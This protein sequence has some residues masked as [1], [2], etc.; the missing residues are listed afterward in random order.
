[1]IDMARPIISFKFEYFKIMGIQKEANL[2]HVFQVHYDK[3]DKDFIAYDTCY[4]GEKGELL[5]YQLPKTE[6]LCLLFFSRNGELFTTLRKW[7]PEMERY[8]KSMTGRWFEVKI[9]AKE[10]SAGQ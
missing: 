9:N 8:Y 2:L 3:L 6:L 7:N 10:N 1:V 5:Y 4:E